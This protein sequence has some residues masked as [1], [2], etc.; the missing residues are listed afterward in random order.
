M[1]RKALLFVVVAV[2]G[3]STLTGGYYESTRRNLDVTDQQRVPGD[4]S[5]EFEEALSTIRESYG[6]E[7]DLEELGKQSIQGMLNQLDPH[8]AFFTKEEFDDLQTETRSRIHGIGVTIQ[9]RN[10][11]VYIISVVP[12]GPAYKAGLRYGDAIVAL[13][14]QTAEEWSS[15]QVMHRVRGELGDPVEITVERAG[16]PRPI[17]VT[18]RRGEVK[19]PS[20]RNAFMVGQAGIGYIALTGGFSSK[21]SEE[22]ALALAQLKQEGMH[23]LILDLRGNP[24]G[25]LDQ[26]IEVAQMFLPPGLKILDQRG[27]DGRGERTYEVPE[28]N[29]PETIPMVLIINRQTAS[30][31]EIVAGA[32][33]DHDRAII[34]GETSFGKGLVQ[35][36]IRLWGG[37]GLTLTTAKYYTPTGRLIQR[38][39]SRMSFYDYYRNR[40]GGEQAAGGAPRGNALRTDLGREVYEGG[41]IAP[42]IE[43]KSQESSPVRIRLFYGI[44][45]FARELVAGQVAGMRRYRIAE[46]A[47]KGKLSSEDTDR[48]PITDDLLSAFRQHIA[49]RP[50]FNISEE[51]FAANLSY[52]RAQLRREII[53]AAFGPQAGDQVYL[54]EDV[55]VRKAIESLDQARMLADN[56]R[57]ARGD[58]Q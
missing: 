35:S 31:S 45:D 46:T 34:V 5:L 36:V 26:A 12:D 17:T 51:Q 22:L 28:N 14:G 38:D 29:E 33:Q 41:G 10:D 25:L 53:T 40:F 13:D 54:L 56:A 27:R 4:I 44:F 23:N 16:A 30:A 50:Q 18:I 32:L 58:R 52:I 42:D 47:H 19:L 43:V 55:Q 37:A 20:V 21:T 1:N 9:K 6:G 49:A 7:A 8:S 48:Y 24:G 57:R 15:E 3:A 11:R 39:Y 2:I